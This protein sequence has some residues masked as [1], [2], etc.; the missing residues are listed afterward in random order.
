M[1]DNKSCMVSV[2]L[3]QSDSKLW[4]IR[5]YPLDPILKK[6][7]IDLREPNSDTHIGR[8]APL[9]GA[10]GAALCEQYDVRMH[11]SPLSRDRGYGLDHV[12][13][14]TVEG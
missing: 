8:V 4:R 3:T 2:E 7:K 5:P 6:S 12:R 1:E 11:E 9:G 13:L 10:D 14:Q